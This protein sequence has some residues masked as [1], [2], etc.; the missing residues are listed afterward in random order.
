MAEDPDA[1]RR[2]AVLA[3]VYEQLVAEL[4]TGAERSREAELRALAGDVESAL[5]RCRSA[6]RSRDV[7]RTMPQR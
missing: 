7:P 1:Q 4:D 2:A 6:Q 5:N 3:R